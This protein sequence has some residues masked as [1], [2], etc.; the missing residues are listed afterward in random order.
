MLEVPVTGEFF[1]SLKRR[2]KN[3]IGLVSL[4]DGATID[5]NFLCSPQSKDWPGISTL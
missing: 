2:K 1:F 5:I 4:E 3:L